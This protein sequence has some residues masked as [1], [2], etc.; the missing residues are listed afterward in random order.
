MDIL[1]NELANAI[2]ADRREHAARERRARSLRA[3]RWQPET[4]TSR[5]RRPLPRWTRPSMPSW[6]RLMLARAR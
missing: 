5:A 4:S 6:A 3:D 2:L 1:G